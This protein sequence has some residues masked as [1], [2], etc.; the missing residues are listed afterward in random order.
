MKMFTFEAADHRTG[1]EH[2]GWVHVPGGAT[3]EFCDFVREEVARGGFGSPVPRAGI[4]VSKEQFV[5][6]LPEEN[7]IEELFDLAGAMCG[8][9][10]NELTLSERHVNVYSPGASPN[11]RPHKDRFASQ[12]SIGVSIQVP[13]GSYLAL[14]PDVAC[15]V[16][17]L[18]RAGL[19]DTVLPDDRPEVAL[20]GSK[21]VEIFDAPGHVQV[22]RGSAIWHTRRN[23]AGAVVLYFK[24]NDFGSDP[25]AEDPSTPERRQQ[26]ISISAD[27]SRLRDADARLG[28]RFEAITH[29]ES[30]GA[31]QDWY[32]VVVNG[33][34]PMRITQLEVDLLRTLDGTARIPEI[35]GPHGA[36]GED[37]LRRLVELGAIDVLD[38]A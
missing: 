34:P 10:R 17:P 25:L 22:F 7:L 33:Q 38:P 15:T 12:V 5:L 26:S 37:A 30:L 31:R 23:P 4:T 27:R 28:R 3:S 24:V 36:A 8:L 13:E 21:P 16:N 11:P 32:N 20:R 14:W 9:D 1:F 29:E 18:Q 6:E 2:Q 19:Q 35:V